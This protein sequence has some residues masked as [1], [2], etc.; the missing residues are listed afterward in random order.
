MSDFLSYFYIITTIIHNFAISPSGYKTSQNTIKYINKMTTLKKQT[1]V[2]L[3]GLAAALTLNAQQPTHE[4]NKTR[5]AHLELNQSMGKQ[6]INDYY[7]TMM[8]RKPNQIDF[9]QN[10]NAESSNG[11]QAQKQTNV[12]S[13]LDVPEDMIFPIESDEV[14]AILIEWPYITRNAS[15][16]QYAEA[17]F[18]GYGL[19]YD[20]FGNYSLVQTV[21]TPDVADNS[22][23]ALLHAKLTNAIQK[24]A[25]VWIDV[26]YDEDTVTI[27][28]FMQKKGMPLENYRFFVHPGNSFWA[29]D[30]GPVA[31]YYG[32]DDSIAFMDFEY[33]G[34]RPMDDQLPKQIA[35]NLGWNCYTTTVEYEGGNILTDGLGS[36]FTTSA[37]DTTNSDRYGLYELDL[38]GSE[39]KLTMNWKTP[40]THQQLEDSIKHLMN[41]QNIT[42]VPMLD[43]DGGTGHIDLCADMW[44]ETGF[45]AAKYPES[46]SSWGDAKK[47][48][49]NLET[50]TSQKNYFGNNYDLVRVPLPA[51]DN[52]SWYLSPREYNQYTRC[53][54]NHTFV[55]DAIIQPVFYDTSLSGSKAGDTEGNKLAL[56]VL[57]KAY[58]GY[59]F[60]EIDV[61]SFDGYGGAI[62]CITKQIPA[63]NPVRI[64]HQPARFFNTQEN[65]SKY[66][67]EVFSQNKSG[68]KD[69]KI[70]FKTQSANQ[71]SDITLTSLGDNK[72]AGDITL[73]DTATN[74]TLYYYISSTSNNGKTMLKPMTA[75]QGGFYVMPYG[76]EVNTYNN[77]YAWDTVGT[78]VYDTSNLSY[79]TTTV[80]Y[81]TQSDIHFSS[82]T[83]VTQ[84][85]LSDISE[86]Y[87]N[88]AKDN[89]VITV[90]NN[91]D[92]YYRIIN[93]KGQVQQS[94]KIAK[95]TV[96]YELDV[97]NLKSGHYWVI[98]T[99]GN[100][101]ASR[102]LIITK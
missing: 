42:F 65:G 22:D 45:V 101:S 70:Y 56:D 9:C 92:L 19:V 8:Q 58:P 17:I 46:L 40:L 51:K 102:N 98:F 62:H 4:N 68:I 37:V 32:D 44:E 87:P 30:W 2:L 67:V 57:K 60:E 49:S 12:K 35:A 90:N 27:K 96:N 7:R 15:N 88:P 38:S 95:N 10:Q 25:Q 31:F 84:K 86:I 18:D 97:K 50:F 23:Y 55:N 5:A 93:L 3:L 33:Y 36:L 81:G 66:H 78:V 43:Y 72:F 79:D 48:E 34:G 64:Y 61:R 71:W 28:N 76:K 83:S 75:H 91:T 82:L 6:E 63:D 94:G 100:F 52:G 53:W 41:L 69:V 47:V 77:D 20:F 1:L 13:A 26:W 39:P 85:T 59:T 21:S 99:D 73:N 80:T 89:A 24:H 74:D 11:E 14:Q 16:N 29:R 54:A